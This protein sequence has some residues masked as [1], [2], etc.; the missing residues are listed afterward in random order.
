MA[1]KGDDYR[2]VDKKKF[3]ETMDRVFG[4]RDP[5]EYQKGGHYD[6]K[7]RSRAYISPPVSPDPTGT[8]SNTTTV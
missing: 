7:E 5:I 1:G 6:S 8:I 3:D 4:E 2:P